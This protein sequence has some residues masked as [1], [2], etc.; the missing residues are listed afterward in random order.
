MVNMPNGSFVSN[1]NL[2]DFQEAKQLLAQNNATKK[3]GS[4]AK[5]MYNL[6]LIVTQ[7]SWQRED[8]ERKT[9]N[10]REFLVYH[11]VLNRIVVSDL[12]YFLCSTFYIN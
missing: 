4:M 8:C 11:M 7:N 3:N 9:R 2:L 10:F 12:A 6:Y 5:I 1:K